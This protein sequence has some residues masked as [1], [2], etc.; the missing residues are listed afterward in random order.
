MNPPK[1]SSISAFTETN[2][3]KILTCNVKDVKDYDVLV[4]EILKISIP[5]VCLQECPD[6]VP[7][8]DMIMRSFK[9]NGYSGVRFAGSSNIIYLRS[10]A[11]PT[12][13]EYITFTN[14][15][16]KRGLIV[17][18][19]QLPLTFAGAENIII[20]REIKICTSQLESG[21]TGGGIRKSQIRDLHTILIAND[22]KVKKEKVDDD[23]STTASTSGGGGSVIFV[24]DTNISTWQTELNLTLPGVGNPRW[25][26]AWREKGTSE[27]ECTNIE[28]YDRMDRVWYYSP[29]DNLKCISYNL[30]SPFPKATRLG[31]IVEFSLV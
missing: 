12:K 10:D 17:Y 11:L 20:T 29:D 2:S 14:T 22:D 27:N 23:K 5:I 25:M 4:A 15:N 9:A 1:P 28:T 19:Y 16:Q 31:V 7:L 26:D 30:F 18:T 8:K 13:K 24:G 3:I 21:G 6:Q